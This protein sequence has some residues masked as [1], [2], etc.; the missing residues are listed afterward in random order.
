MTPETLE[1]LK[2]SIAK[3]ERN[4]EIDDLER[5][6]IGPASCP[7]CVLFHRGHCHRC[8]ITNLNERHY[9]C[10]HT[11]YDEAESAYAA[12]RTDDFQIA[13]RA[14]VTFLKSLLPPDEQVP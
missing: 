12:G 2:A 9:R 8:P 3:W 7:L 10:G 14:E 6:A 11:P 1:A 5:A 13:A 4:A